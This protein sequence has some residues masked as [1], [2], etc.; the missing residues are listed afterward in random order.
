[1]FSTSVIADEI[2]FDEVVA[3]DISGEL[4]DA[5]DSL[6]APLILLGKKAGELNVNVRM[7][8][9]IASI[10]KQEF[11]EKT[12]KY[13]KKS[14]YNKLN[15]IDG[16][17]LL[18]KDFPN[19]ITVSLDEMLSVVITLTPEVML[20]IDPKILNNSPKLRP[21]LQQPIQSI[22]N[23]INVRLDH[24]E[25]TTTN[26]GVHTSI[27]YNRLLFTGASNYNGQEMSIFKENA[28]L[29]YE[30]INKNYLLGYFN[31]PK[32][33]EV[34]GEKTLGISIGNTKL[35]NYIIL[36]SDR[37]YLDLT[38]PS[39]VKIYIGESLH[40]DQDLNAG[41]HSLN[42]PLNIEPS[43]IKVQIEDIY[44]RAKN[45]AF[46]FAGNFSNHIPKTGQ[47]LYFASL[48]KNLKN[49][50]NLYSGLEFGLN[51]LSKLSLAT[52]IYAKY[53]LFGISYYRLFKGLNLEN[54]LVLSQADSLG[55]KIKTNAFIKNFA[56][57]I[58]LNWQ[59]DF[60]NLGI[61]QDDTL[62]V[63]ASKK[64]IINDKFS[65]KTNAHIDIL[66]NET[67]YGVFAEYKFSKNLDANL[68]YESNGMARFSLNWM[69]GKDTQLKTTMDAES[70][71]I[72]VKHFFNEHRN[73]EAQYYNGNNLVAVHD[74]SSIF[75]T[76]VKLNKYQEGDSKIELRSNFSIVASGGKMGISKTIGGGGFVIFDAG[77]GLENTILATLGDDEC[78]ISQQGSCIIKTPSNRE[79]MPSYG[80][81]EIGFDK[82]ITGIDDPIYIPSRGGVRHIVN[83]HKIYF[84]QA[85]IMSGNIPLELLIGKIVDE[86][87][88][89]QDIFTDE[90]GMIFAQLKSGTYTMKFAEFQDKKVIIKGNKDLEELDLGIITIILK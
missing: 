15:S 12:Q 60:T 61:L 47:Y 40:S 64:F 17:F 57:N 32:F 33:A 85:Q 21:P 44:G 81:G 2:F 58:R 56:T 39:N 68:S 84:V 24:Q 30:D 55:V 3:S 50:I 22:I 72:G 1:L 90:S 18:V 29:N 88:K 63:L 14:I 53:Q 62:E 8:M 19:G 86:S 78:S 87:G 77:E 36:E 27:R 66:T 89:E 9:T 43:M 80:L 49:Q 41:K 13:L 5:T 71:N 73:I 69:L 59:Q 82:V 51:K 83:A 48:G 23:D 26:L 79:I 35:N 42:I 76:R 37:K 46:E 25:E 38:Y 6:I 31:P 7:D 28:L 74:K 34:S 75:N 16:D 65:F 52:S 67:G 45:I 54:T 4:S 10:D 11:L 20:T 70:Q